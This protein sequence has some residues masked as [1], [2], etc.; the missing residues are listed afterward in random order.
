MVAGWGLVAAV[1]AM[2]VGWVQGAAAKGRAA[3]FQSWEAA[4]RVAVCLGLAAARSGC[5][6]QKGRVG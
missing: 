4:A 6:R 2:A 5:K 3:V 1:R